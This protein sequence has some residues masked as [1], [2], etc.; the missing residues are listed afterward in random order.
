MTI[1][2]F[3]RRA[4]LKRSSALG[5]A[6]RASATGLPAGFLMSGAMPV[7]GQSLTDKTLV[8]AMSD[9]GESIN[10]YAPGTYS[11]NSNDA[12]SAIARPTTGENGSGTLGQVNGRDITVDDFASPATI[13]MGNTQVEAAKFFS[14][15]PQNML[16]RMAMLHIRTNA[17]GHPE[18]GRV[19]GV[20]GTLMDE[21]GR[22][23]EEIQSA[24]MQEILRA[25]PGRP[26]V[27]NTPMV[28]NGGGGRLNSLNHQG[29]AITRY[30][31]EDVKNL[32]AGSGGGSDVENMAKLYESTIDSIYKDVKTNGTREQ[33]KYLDAHASSRAQATTLGDQLGELM[34]DVNGDSR[35]D[36]VK[37]AIAMAKVN[38][39]PVIV[40]RYSYSQDNHGDE[41]LSD[42][43]RFTIEQ[44]NNLVTFWDLVEAEGMEDRINY[45]TYDIFGRTLLRNN[46]G[47]R[48]HHNSSCVNMM[49]GSNIQ[50]GVIGGLEEWTKSGT[51]HM[52][53]TAINSNT[54]LSNNADIPGDET[55]SSYAKTLMAFMGIEQS[56]IDVRVSAGKT[57]NASFKS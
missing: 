48:D 44:L 16:D 31:P 34:A 17:N 53:S 28:L 38:L 41:N 54:G 50:P 8:L 55:L 25:N 27:L 15:L 32:F 49:I 19:H 5:F 36:Q 52:R 9:D 23:T 6:L 43:I 42:E 26:T 21:T 22:G 12:R 37:A 29:V 33:R 40:I 14:V 10:A 2:H 20:N 39:A 1:N 45:A 47:G 30:S 11:T 18:G 3:N 56:R 13:A 7:L 57:I 51:R 35:E 46:D 4:F 24:I